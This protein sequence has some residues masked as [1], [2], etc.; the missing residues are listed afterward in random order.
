MRIDLCTCD[1]CGKILDMTN[2]SHW[3]GY[4]HLYAPTTI[5]ETVSDPETNEEVT[6][7]HTKMMY[8]AP[9]QQRPNALRLDLCEPCGRQFRAKVLEAMCNKTFKLME[10]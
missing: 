5:T 6:A 7:K 4:I 9:L 8:A 10:E 3:S 2:E 1:L